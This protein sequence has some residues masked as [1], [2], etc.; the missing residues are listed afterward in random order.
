MSS[1]ED[2]TPRRL[3]DFLRESPAQGLLNPAVA[4]SRANAVEQLFV[5]LTDKERADLRLVDVDKLA[6][7]LHKIEGS[8]IRP[9]VVALYKSRVQEALTDYFN[10][11]QNPKTFATIGGHA[12]RR[13]K[14]AFAEGENPEEVRALEDI[15]LA[16]S[17]RRKDYITVPLRKDLA[18][19]ITGI[20][21]DLN[22]DEAAKIS[23]VVMA[24]A[25]PG[26]VG[27]DH[28]D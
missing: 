11:L 2:Y 20:P 27:V 15:A 23:R 26:A 19:Y 6:S 10:W 13:D 12:L 28:A 17:E 21:L 18:V 24:L 4:R 3:L 14:R 9:E 16:T 22:R 1:T 5:E 7:R 8:T 25:Q